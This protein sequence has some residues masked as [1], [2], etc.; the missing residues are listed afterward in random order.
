VYAS[1]GGALIAFIFN[2]L[3]MSI[4]FVTFSAI[5]KRINKSWGSWLLI[6]LWM[7][8]EHWHTIWDLTWTWLNIGNVFAFSH[9]WVQWY[10]FTGASGGTMWALSV[11]VLVYQTIRNNSSLRFLSKPVMKIEAAILIPML[12]SYFI[13]FVRKSHQ[14]ENK[15]VETVVVQPNID[16]YNDKFNWDFSYQFSKATRLLEGKVSQDAAYIVFPETFITDNLNEESINDNDAI[17]WFKDSLLRR[18]PKARIITGANTYII[19]K[20]GEETST[21]RK[22]QRGFYYDIFNSAL[23]IDSTGVSIYHKSKLVPGVERMPFPALLKPLESFAINL[24]GTMGSL[25]TQP[26]RS[27]FADTKTGNAIAPV[28]CYESI[29]ADYGTEYVRKGATLIFIITNDGWW[30]NTPGYRQHLNYARLRAIESRRE[31]ARSANTGISCFV[32]QFGNFSQETLWWQD[33]VIVAKLNPSHE[34]TF[35]CRFGDLLSY[36]AVTLSILLVLWGLFL[37]F[38]K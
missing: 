9:N 35:F 33:A 19:Y 26:E 21:A 27:V 28:I 25:G 29:F 37:R 10:E 24:G 3:F 14:P 4:V 15:R 23:Q 1:A 7:A 8:W 20:N 36:I 30:D 12:L 5:K 2:A 22:D 34:L 13:F 6:P 32:D 11:N 31:I 16:P 38:R 18:F 17:S